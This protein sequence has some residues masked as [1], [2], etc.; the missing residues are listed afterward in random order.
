M[1]PGY[2]ARSW[3]L[4]WEAIESKLPPTASQ[5]WFGLAP[6]WIGFPESAPVTTKGYSLIG[7]SLNRTWQGGFPRRPGSRGDPKANAGA[8]EMWVIDAGHPLYPSAPP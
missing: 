1:G 8:L 6:T 7:I 4:R 2:R 5:P 3:R